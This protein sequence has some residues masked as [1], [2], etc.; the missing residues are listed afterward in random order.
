MLLVERAGATCSHELQYCASFHSRR[1]EIMR[2]SVHKHPVDWWDGLVRDLIPGTNQAAG[3]LYVSPF[4]AQRFGI[5]H[6][7]TGPTSLVLSY[8]AR[9]SIHTFS[10]L[11]KYPLIDDIF[12]QRE[13][14]SSGLYVTRQ[15]EDRRRRFFCEEV[16]CQKYN[17]INSSSQISEKF[18]D[19][20]FGYAY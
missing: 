7:S 14:D 15:Y 20:A 8:K 16:C 18:I 13:S 2:C 17:D 5:R 6:L 19:R 1:R 12:T 4:P 11:S 9:T 3:I 10:V